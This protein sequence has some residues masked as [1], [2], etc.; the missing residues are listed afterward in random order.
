M[1]YFPIIKGHFPSWFPIWGSEDFEFFRPVFNF[2]DFSISLGVALIIWNHK[3]FFG[4][5]KVEQTKDSVS[6]ASEE[7]SEHKEIQDNM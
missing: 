1:F 3:K 5:K 6:N 2:A 4:A 7:T